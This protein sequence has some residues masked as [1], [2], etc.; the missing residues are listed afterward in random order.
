[1]RMSRSILFGYALASVS[2]LPLA[3]SH[4]DPLYAALSSLAL[5]PLVVLIYLLIRR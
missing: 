2:P 3:V 5:S 4:E 1:M